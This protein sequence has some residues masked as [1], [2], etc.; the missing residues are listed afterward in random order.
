VKGWLPL[1]IGIVAVVVGAVWT[2]QGL[3]Y[4][5]GSVMTDER[6]WA[7]IGP[8]VAVAGLVSI[9]FALRIRRR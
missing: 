2:V 8:L 9:V 6:I 7:V 4:L 5:S 3:G 1:A